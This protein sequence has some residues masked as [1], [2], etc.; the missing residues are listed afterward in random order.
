MHPNDSFFA[1]HKYVLHVTNTLTKYN[2]S[3]SVVMRDPLEITIEIVCWFANVRAH[4][5][6]L[7][8]RSEQHYPIP[9]IGFRWSGL[10]KCHLHTH[11]H[12]I[13][14]HFPARSSCISLI[15]IFS[16]LSIFST[17]LQQYKWTVNFRFLSVYG[18]IVSDLNWWYTVFQRTCWHMQTYEHRHHTFIYIWQCKVAFRLI[19]AFVSLSSTVLVSFLI[20]ALLGILTVLVPLFDICKNALLFC[21]TRSS[22]SGEAKLAGFSRE[23]TE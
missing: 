21:A 13:V 3:V 20:S 10:P 12:N 7:Y 16:S 1:V 23:K 6:L 19:H 9:L 4:A 11:S 5:P 14:S 17:L 2:L 18:D 8:H 15:F 22:P